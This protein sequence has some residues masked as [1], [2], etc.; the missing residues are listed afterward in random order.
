MPIEFPC[1]QCSSLLRTPDTS[2]GKKAKCPKC[3]AI[4]EVPSTSTLPDQTLPPSDRPFEMAGSSTPSPS[5]SPPPMPQRPD[6]D[7]PFAESSASPFAPQKPSDAYNPYATPQGMEPDQTAWTG[8]GVK[9]LQHRQIDFGEVFH[10]SWKCCTDNLGPCLLLGLVL[11]GIGIALQIVA[12][13]LQ[14][15]AAATRSIAIV[16][17]VQLLFF[18]FNMLVQVAIQLGLW[19]F[20]I[21][22]V[23]DNRADVGEL[24]GIG[25]FIV[26]GILATVLI[27]LITIVIMTVC[28]A[29][30]AIVIAVL[31]GERAFKDMPFIVIPLIVVFSVVGVA[32][33]IWISFRLFLMMPL[34]VDRDLD[35]M[36]AVRQS[37]HFM[38]G[39]KLTTFLTMMVAGLIAM[40]ITLF[41]CCLGALFA[42]PYIAV[43]ISTIYLAATGQ[44]TQKGIS[45]SR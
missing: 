5:G 36:D 20:G 15:G 40:A 22:L 33:L 45:Y 9:Q 11:V 7:N 24:F 1:P 27:W 32:A 2:G 34:I 41:T 16:I 26:R 25:R 10:T 44:L 4:A 29:P 3:G 28:V 39:N 6:L 31:G 30:P 38:A 42:Y 37:D 21:H 14:F 43:T 13:V 35:V 23:R 17:V 8:G 19:N 12:Q 18:V